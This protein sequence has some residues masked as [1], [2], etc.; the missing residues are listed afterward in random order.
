MVILEN[1]FMDLTIRPLV[2]NDHEGN[3][4]TALNWHGNELYS[5]DN[6]GKVS[7]FTLVI[8]KIIF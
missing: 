4:V 1:F 8:I 7:V 5:G 2:L 6:S 3:M